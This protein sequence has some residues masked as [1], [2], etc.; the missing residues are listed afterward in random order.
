V[1]KGETIG[2]VGSTGNST[3]AHLH[4]EI[5]INGTAV[6]PFVYLP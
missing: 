2:Y 6:N 4:F 1:V 3:G 5:D